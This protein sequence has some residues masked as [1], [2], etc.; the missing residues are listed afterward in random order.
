MN[1]S[2]GIL[3]QACPGGARILRVFGDSPCPALPVQIEGF[4]VVEIGPYCFAQKDVY[5]RQLQVYFASG[6][7]A[8]AVVLALH[9]AGIVAPDLTSE[10]MGALRGTYGYGHPNTFGGLVFGLVLAYALLRAQKV[11]WMDCLLVFAVGVF[12]LVGPASRSAALCTL[13]LLYTSPQLRKNGRSASQSIVAS[14]GSQSR[15]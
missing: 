12:L 5:K 13:C 7:A 2:L 1:S 14:Y 10:R 4:P 6:C 15:K 9:F 3:W 11:R 8:M